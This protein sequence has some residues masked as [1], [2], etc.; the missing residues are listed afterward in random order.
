MKILMLF[1]TKFNKGEEGIRTLG[2][3][4]HTRLAIELFRPLRHFSILFLSVNLITIFLLQNK[5]KLR[6]KDSNL[7]MTG[8]KPVALPLGYTPYVFFF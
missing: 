1:R 5:I 7:R 2:V 4:T 6:W 8:P 3:F